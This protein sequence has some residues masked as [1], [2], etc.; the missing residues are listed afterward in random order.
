[1]NL[2]YK[3]LLNPDLANN[4]KV[5]VYQ[6]HRLLSI[7]EALEAAQLIDDFTN[8]WQSHG[9]DVKANGYLFFGRFVV[10]LADETHTHVGGCSTDSSVRFIKALGEKFNVDFFDRTQLAFVIKNEIQLLPFTQVEYALA[11]DFITTETLYF[12]NLV[13]TKKELEENWIIPVKESW[14]A[15]K[16]NLPV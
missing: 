1:M 16:I 9:S 11:H 15:K 13:S 7:N 5:W 6:A 10:L 2:L 14:L 12:N 8:Q 4:S 3:Q